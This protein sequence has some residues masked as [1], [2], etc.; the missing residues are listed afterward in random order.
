MI[1]RY[2]TAYATWDNNCAPT[3]AQHCL[4]YVVFDNQMRY[5]SGDEACSRFSERETTNGL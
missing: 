3:M 5:A 4:C 1:T 2:C